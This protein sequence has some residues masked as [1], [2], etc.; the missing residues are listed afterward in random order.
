M[1][2]ILKLEGGKNVYVWCSV[3]LYKIGDLYK[4]LKIIKVNQI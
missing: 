2:C 3:R 1:N 4:G